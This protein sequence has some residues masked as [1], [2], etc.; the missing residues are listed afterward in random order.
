MWH[1]HQRVHPAER[2][3]VIGP[4]GPGSRTDGANTGRDP[5][6]IGIGMEWGQDRDRDGDHGD[7]DRDD[8]SR[9]CSVIRGAV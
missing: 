9:A 1:G 5:L 7:H 6:G 2:S 4:I 8:P 3:A